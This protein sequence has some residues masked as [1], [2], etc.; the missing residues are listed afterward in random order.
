MGQLYPIRFQRVV[1]VSLHFSPY[2]LEFLRVLLKVLS[3]KELGYR[4]GVE[5][6]VVGKA[7]SAVCGV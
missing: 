1:P 5:V 4:V 7:G 2:I 6:G 3:A